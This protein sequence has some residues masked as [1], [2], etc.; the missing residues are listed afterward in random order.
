MH[1]TAAVSP[2]ICRLLTAATAVYWCASSEIFSNCR[3]SLLI[4]MLPNCGGQLWPMSACHCFIQVSP[5][6]LFAHTCAPRHSFQQDTCH[7]NANLSMPAFAITLQSS[8]HVFSPPD[9]SLSQAQNL[10]GTVVYQFTR[11]FCIGP[12]TKMN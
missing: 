1:V 12:A 4:Q 6:G 2:R 10:G 11:E 7:T 3:Q 5:L 8:L 9:V